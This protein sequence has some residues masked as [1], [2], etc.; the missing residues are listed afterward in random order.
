MGIRSTFATN[1]QLER[2]GRW[3]DLTSVKNKNGTS[4]GFRLARMHKNNPEYSAA[5]EKIA[6]E[7]RQAIDLDI[8]T[9]DVASPIMRRVFVETVLLDWRN[10]WDDA[11]GNGV[12]VEIPY[13]KEAADKYMTEFTDLYMLLI[14]EARKL[15]NYRKA[16]VT[17]VS[18]KSSQ[19]LNKPSGN[20]AT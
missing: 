13:S 6:K 18:E 19:R 8:L 5:V 15:S 2:E 16:E 9:E 14:E 12:E 17:A 7:L 20:D 11:E 1:N 10:F 4:P 3:F